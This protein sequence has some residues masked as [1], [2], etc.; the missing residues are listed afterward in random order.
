MLHFSSNLPQVCLSFKI[1]YKFYIAAIF[2]VTELPIVL[3]VF[4]RIL[5]I[6]IIIFQNLYKSLFSI[7]P[8]KCFQSSWRNVFNPTPGETFLQ[9]DSFHL[10]RNFLI[11]PCASCCNQYIAWK[12]YKFTEYFHFFS[13]IVLL[14][15][16]SYIT[17]SYIF[18]LAE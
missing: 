14:F 11:F 3:S 16:F 7:L 2:D 1:Q 12:T 5:F 6:L 9:I 15:Y 13:S 10:H 18:F 17:L 8:E 4:F